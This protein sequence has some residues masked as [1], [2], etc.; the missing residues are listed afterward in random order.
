MTGRQT[1]VG[2]TTF[3]TGGGGGGAQEA[4]FMYTFVGGDLVP[5]TQNPGFDATII[6]VQMGPS[7]IGVAP[8]EVVSYF[9]LGNFPVGAPNPANFHGVEHRVNAPADQTTIAA[10]F[11]NFINL[12]N[13]TLG[14]VFTATVVKTVAGIEITPS[15]NTFGR[16]SVSIGMLV[17]G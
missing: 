8:A 1:Y 12:R 13:D 17:R 9:A 5:Q 4:F 7:I 10:P 15:V 14:L 16:D 2:P 3:A 6:Q 11:G